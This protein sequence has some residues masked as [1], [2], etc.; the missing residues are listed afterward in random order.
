MSHVPL[1]T[2]VRLNTFKGKH[3]FLKKRIILRGFF[4]PPYF[5]PRPRA[6]KGLNVWPELHPPPPT[7]FKMQIALLPQPALKPECVCVG[8]GEHRIY[9]SV[10]LC[11]TGFGASG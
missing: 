4:I 2:C 3:E 6:G 7:H 11:R 8:G 9:I 5:L 1:Q 10:G